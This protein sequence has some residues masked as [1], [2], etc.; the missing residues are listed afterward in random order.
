MLEIGAEDAPG[1]G[2]S[3]FPA[4]AG[5]SPVMCVTTAKNDTFSAVVATIHNNDFNFFFNLKSIYDN[6]VIADFQPRLPLIL[7]PWTSAS[8]PWQS[9]VELS[10]LQPRSIFRLSYCVISRDCST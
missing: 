5:N 3:F 9:Y 10:F 7:N 1:F 4:S 8:Y 2:R 6:I